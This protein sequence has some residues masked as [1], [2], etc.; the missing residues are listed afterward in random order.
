[1][2]VL[3]LEQGTLKKYL[4]YSKETG[5]FTW[6]NISKYHIE[7]NGSIA[8]FIAKNGYVVIKI[9][10]KKYKAH[11]LAWLYV[12]GYMPKYGIDHIN[13]NRSDNRI[14]N[15]RDVSASINSKN[16]HK[17]KNNTSGFTGVGFV[18]KSNRWRARITVDGVVIYLGN[19]INFHEAVNARK[20]A[21]V[22]Y[23]F[24]KNHG[25]DI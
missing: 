6:K 15:L 5:I 16:R 1:M 20:N 3:N 18:A 14:E 11:R 22:L 21:E 9:N 4:K 12:Y 23:G 8:G 25:K 19:F 10:G 2:Q 17:H 24:H 13:H 7:K